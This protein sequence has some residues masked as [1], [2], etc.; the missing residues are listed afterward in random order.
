[1]QMKMQPISMTFTELNNYY[2]KLIDIR[3]DF[4]DEELQFRKDIWHERVNKTINILNGSF[5]LGD[6]RISSEA[7]KAWLEEGQEL[8]FVNDAKF[9]KLNEIVEDI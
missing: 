6:E 3:L 9:E 4:E 8:E 5:E 7:I 1:M 2:E